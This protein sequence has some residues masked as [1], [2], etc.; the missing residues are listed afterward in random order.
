VSDIP[1]IEHDHR[2]PLMADGGPGT[3]DDL[4]HI[5]RAAK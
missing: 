5:G 4:E 1:G 3:D 2:R